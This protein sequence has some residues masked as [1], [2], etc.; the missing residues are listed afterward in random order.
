MKKTTVMYLILICAVITGLTAAA[1]FYLY[2]SE[3][4]KLQE[5]WQAPPHFNNS[6]EKIRWIADMNGKGEPIGPPIYKPSETVKGLQ[7]GSLLMGGITIL[8]LGLSFTKKEI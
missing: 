1:G 7:Y 3:Q 2:K 4:A 5:G 8:L 6:L